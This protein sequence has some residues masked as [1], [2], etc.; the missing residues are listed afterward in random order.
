MDYS[1]LNLRKDKD[2]IIPRASFASTKETFRSDIEKLENLYS[3]NEILNTLKSTKERISNNVCELVAK[4][5]HTQKFSRF[6]K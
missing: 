2:I 3:A 1:K 5:Y 4:R 6:S